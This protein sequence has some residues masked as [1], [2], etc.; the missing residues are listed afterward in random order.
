[1]KIENTI[2]IA[3]NRAVNLVRKLRLRTKIYFQKLD[4]LL[5]Y[6]FAQ[7]L[8]E[9]LVCSLPKRDKRKVG[10]GINRD[11]LFSP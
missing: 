10:P 7:I 11:P 2:P 5:T 6:N 9:I 1:M 8:L 3:V 4:V